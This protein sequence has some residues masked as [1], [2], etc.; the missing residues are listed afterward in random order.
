M[1]LRVVTY[2]V[3]ES[4]HGAVCLCVLKCSM[5]SS[6]SPP[7]YF[8][9]GSL[10]ELWSAPNF[11]PKAGNVGAVLEIDDIV[12]TRVNIFDQSPESVSCLLSVLSAWSP[13]PPHQGNCT[14]VRHPQE[15]PGPLLAGHPQAPPQDV[16]RLGCARVPVVG[17]H[18]FF[19]PLRVL[20]ITNKGNCSTQAFLQFS[21]TCL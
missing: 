6:H 15:C 2:C 13:S 8:F 9:E 18:V 3:L 1:C 4:S 7:Q 21:R 14:G 16:Q 12:T 10:T 20:M 17:A 11:G 5:P 19:P